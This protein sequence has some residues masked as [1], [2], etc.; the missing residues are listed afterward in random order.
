MPS[1]ARALSL[2]LP[3]SLSICIYI[4]T[5]VYINVNTCAYT[6][7]HKHTHAH[8]VHDSARKVVADETREHSPCKPCV[9]VCVRVCVRA[10]MCM[11][12]CMHNVCMHV[13]TNVHTKGAC[14]CMHP[15]VH[16]YVPMCVCQHTGTL[17]TQLTSSVLVS[18]T[19][20]RSQQTHTDRRAP[21]MQMD[22][23]SSSAASTRARGSN[24][25]DR[26]MPCMHS[27]GR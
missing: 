15:C 9:C 21:V 22:S 10:C 6:H 17:N 27:Y 13:S 20:T 7:T 24:A 3:L 2:S 18:V 16:V 25:N 14:M 1:R 4:Y 5:Y 19:L 12:L 26:H 11:Y 23:G 8:R